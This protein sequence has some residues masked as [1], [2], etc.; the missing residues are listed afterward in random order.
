[1]EYAALFIALACVFGFFMAWGVGANDVANAMGTSVGSR[2][3]T[4]KQAVFVA[5]IFEFAGAWLAGGEVT[6][7]IRSGMLETG[8][9]E[10]SPEVLVYGMLASLLAAGTWLLVASFFGWPVSTTH[11]IVGA[12]VGFAIVALGMEAVQW[13]R[14]GTI[15]M[16]WVVSPALAGV[17][18]FALFRSVQLL[19]LDTQDPLVNARRFVPFYMFLAAFFTALITL[20]KGLKH[21]GLEFSMLESYVLAAAIGLLVTALGVV[22]IRRLHFEKVSDREFHFTNVEKVFGVLMVVTACAMAFAHG[23]N[24]VANAVGPLAAVVS[25]SQSGEVNAHTPMPMWILL[26]GGAGIVLGLVTYGHK[27]IATVGRNITQLTPSRGFAATLAAAMT[28]VLASGTGLPIS[29][30]HTLVGA[31]LGVGLARGIAAINLGVVRT[32]FMSW[33]ITLP[34]GALLSIIFFLIIRAS[35]S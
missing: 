8:L 4:I 7:T 3:L 34:A 30:T 10:G 17:I 32:V 25:V 18:S 2:A 13:D 24:D 15:A 11:S 12:I 14:V 33:I 27:V 26:L 5:A 16:S 35:F 1:M 6:Q 20:L 23:S 31:I 21:M 29:T 28:V 22:A 19:I 9:L